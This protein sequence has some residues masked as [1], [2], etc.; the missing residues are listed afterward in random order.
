MSTRRIVALAALG[1]AL[2]TGVAFGAS[3]TLRQSQITREVLEEPVERVVI[4]AEGGKVTVRAGVGDRVLVERHER[5]IVSRPEYRRRVLDDELTLRTTCSSVEIAL[6]CGIDLDVFV[7]A[8]VKEVEVVGDEADIRLRGVSGIVRAT[9]GSGTIRSQR[10]DPVVLQTATR[11]GRI[12]LDV[13][14]TPTRIVAR[15]ESGDVGI[16]VPF[17]TYRVD[18]DSRASDRVIGLLRDDLAP[19]RIEASSEDGE[20]RVRAR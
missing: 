1:L 20:V 3:A 8:E 9:T 10:V 6:R 2:L 12:D 4:R 19:Q 7:P 14:G 18:V 13:V 17:A 16:V 15:S 11:S 5:W